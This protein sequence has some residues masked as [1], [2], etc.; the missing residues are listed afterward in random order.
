MTDMCPSVST[1][2]EAVAGTPGEPEPGKLPNSALSR[3]WVL[4]RG[5]QPPASTREQREHLPGVDSPPRG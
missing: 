2:E 3:S 1:Q 4:S 5:I